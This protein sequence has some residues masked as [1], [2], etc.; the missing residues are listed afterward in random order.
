MLLGS[1]ERIGRGDQLREDEGMAKDPKAG[2]AGAPAEQPPKVE[3]K[4]VI[5]DSGRTRRRHMLDAEVRCDWN[6]YTLEATALA[7][8]LVKSIAV[9]A[10]VEEKPTTF[11][12]KTVSDYP[13][14]QV[15]V[16]TVSPDS[17]AIR[18]RWDKENKLFLYCEKLFAKLQIAIPRGKKAY[19]KVHEYMLPEGIPALRIEFSDP[20]YA[21][22]EQRIKGKSQKE[23][24]ATAA[25]ANAAPSSPAAPPNPEAQ[26][27]TN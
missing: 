14:D 2:E 4:P 5:L 18:A 11:N 10:G 25:N 21:P 27:N 17:S 20:R 9:A 22:I 13:N 23:Q 6:S 16:A 19:W 7:A 12:V 15:L 24:S 26:S 3:V 8:D 1:G